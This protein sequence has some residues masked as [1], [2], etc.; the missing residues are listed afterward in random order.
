MGLVFRQDLPVPR[1][2]FYNFDLHGFILAVF[3]FNAVFAFKDIVVFSKTPKFLE[4]S[5]YAVC[6]NVKGIAELKPDGFIFRGMIYAVFT[7]KLD[8]S[9]TVLLVD[10]DD[11]FWQ[12]QSEIFG[13]C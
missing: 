11:T 7:D 6:R 13:L 8:G 10:P 9:V 1:H 3:Q 2:R 5:L 4:V 12:R